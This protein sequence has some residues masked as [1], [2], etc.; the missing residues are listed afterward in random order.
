MKVIQ[1]GGI[2]N[3]FMLWNY[4]DLSG[5]AFSGQIKDIFNSIFGRQNK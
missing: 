3:Q 2:W 1:L 4:K 5:N